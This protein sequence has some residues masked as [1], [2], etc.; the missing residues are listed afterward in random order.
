M[1]TINIPYQRTVFVYRMITCAVT[2]VQLLRI[3]MITLSTFQAYLSSK[4]PLPQLS[5]R[6]INGQEQ[7]LLKWAA[8]LPIQTEAQQAD[9]LEKVLTELSVA[10]SDDKLR[11][12]LISIV[13]TASDRLV[14]TLRE[15]YIRESGAFTDSQLSGIAQVESLYYLSILVYDGIVRRECLSLNYQQQ[16]E[17]SSRHWQRYFTFIKSPPFTLAVAIYQSLLIYQKLLNEKAICYQKPPHSLWT[18]LNQLYYL[19]CQRHVAHIDLSSVVITRHADNIHRLYCQLCLHSLLNVRAMPRPSILLVHRLLP[20]WADYVVA[21]IE[22]QTGTRIFIDLRSDNPPTYLTA[23]STINPYDEQYACLF[24]ELA[25]LATYL[26]LRAQALAEDSS[27]AVVCHLITTVWMTITYRYIQPPLTMPSK[28]SPKQ[29]AT[30]ITGFNDIHYQVA[31]AQSLMSLIAIKELS[32]E[33]QPRY[34]TLPKKHAPSK[35]LEVDTF[36]SKDALSHFRTLRLLPMPNSVNLP[37]AVASAG[38]DPST[39]AP[40]LLRIM[41]LFLLYRSDADINNNSATTPRWS[42]GIGRWLNFATQKTDN[43]AL[44]DQGLDSQSTDNQSTEVEWQV[45][46]HELTACALRLDDRGSRSQHFVPALL[47]GG[48]EQLQTACSLLLPAYHFQINDRVMMR[49]GDRQES[50]RLQ[51]RLLSTESFSQYEVVSL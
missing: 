37:V 12:K 40:P 3:V 29:R 20:I 31:G 19:A 26:Q 49:L 13:V 1:Y 46:G 51:R 16:H 15:H 11:L 35:V 17:P 25:P 14:A 2:V 32:A 50:L 34:D 5:R 4:S 10:D 22:P 18:A 43:Q 39:T 24:I 9:Q 48:D 36:D 38:N 28:Y 23:H 21:T 44:Y 41:S 33:Q 7:Q 42:I 6:Y 47:V 45:L 30:V 27:E 8:L